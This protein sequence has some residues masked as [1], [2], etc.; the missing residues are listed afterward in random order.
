[1]IIH[2]HTSQV[3]L[4][5]YVYV[6]QTSDDTI[7]MLDYVHS[8]VTLHNITHMHCMYISYYLFIQTSIL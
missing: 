7:F 1:M 4:C 3:H 2:V 5:T 8:L 6:Y